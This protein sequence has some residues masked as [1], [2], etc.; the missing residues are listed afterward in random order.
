MHKQTMFRWLI[1]AA[2]AATLAWPGWA[3]E[4]VP[5]E[6]TFRNPP[7]ATRPWCY[8]YWINDQISKE[9]VT[10]DLEAMAQVGIGTALIGNQWFKDQ[11]QGPYPVLGD[12]WQEITLHAIREGTR[13][14][15]DI[16]LFNCPGWS[17]S[18][19]PW[20][21]QA[22]TMRHLVSSE[23]R[24]T[25][26][27][28]FS[29]TIPVPGEDF[30]D[31]ALLAIP[32]PGGEAEPLHSRRPQI[33]CSPDIAAADRLVDGDT[34]TGAM[35]N[36]RAQQIDI[37][38]AKPFTARS[39]TL[40]P[41]GDTYRARVLI[42]AWV[43]GEYR[44]L[45]E[46]KYDR[47]NGSIGAGPMPNGPVI[48]SIPP[49]TSDRFRLVFSVPGSGNKNEKLGDL[50]EIEISPAARVEYAV[51]KQLGKMHPTP[52]PLWGD[53]A[54]PEPP[55][56]GETDGAIAPSE[57]R[58][59]TGQI[60]G[61]GRLTCDIPAGE[62]ILQ[63]IGMVPTGAA[64]SPA[65]PNAR[66]PEIDKM[67]RTHLESHF[68]A[69]VGRVLDR[70]APEER[71]SLKYVVADSY[72]QGSQNWTDGLEAVFKETYGY[73]PIPYL[74]VLGGRIVKSAEASDRF[75]WDLRRMVADRVADEY[76]GG[77]RDL[78][79]QHHMQMWLENYGHW[80]FPSEFMRYGGECDLIAGEFWVT[81]ELGNIECRAAASTAHAYGKP[82]VYAEAFTSGENWTDTPR[83]LKARGDWAF[84]EGINHFVLHVYI[85]Q[86]D[87]RFVPG[88]NAWFGTE[89]NRHNTWFFEGKEWI[90]YLRRCHLL[91]QQGL[92]VGDFAYFIGEDAPIMTGTRQ[93]SQPDG[94]D[95]DFINAE[96]ILERLDV[97]DG[98]WTLPDG[99]SYAVLVLPPLKTMRPAVL[100]KLRDLVAA[101][102]ILYGEAP[103]R[104]PSLQ[105]A[106]QADAL[107]RRLAQEMWPGLKPG[108]PGSAKVGK[109]RVIQGEPLD[110]VV[111]SLGLPPD[112]SRIDPRAV[113][114]T[115]RTTPDREIYFLSNQLEK[116][117]DLAPVFRAGKG[118]VP[119]FWHPDTGRIA[120]SGLFQEL[121]GGTRVP[122]RLDP[123][124]SVFVV[125]R[126][127]EDNPGP[128]VTAVEGPGRLTIEKG[129]AG[130][131]AEGRDGGDYTLHRAGTNP[132]K[133]SLA[134]PPAPL[135]LKDDAW[136]LAFMPGRDAPKEGI[137]LE[138]L[139]FWTDLG[140][141]AVVHY[142][143]TAKYRTAFDVPH[144]LVAQG[145]LRHELNLGTVEPMARVRL[146]GTDLG[147]L[148]KP[149]FAVDVTGILRAG[150]NELEV[151]VTNLWSNR[152]LGELNYPDGFPGKG[153]KEFK[154]ESSMPKK[155]TLERKIQPSGLAGPVQVES[156][157][158]VPLDP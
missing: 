127:P 95:F 38:V 99:K 33:S 111:K 148:W 6:A 83:T 107:V 147:L 81:G 2:L 135:H 89:F 55:A 61:N 45:R 91:L 42:Q 35:L 157:R 122:L 58:N 37:R 23:V 90:D 149:P 143:G 26:P 70:L 78:C 34:A 50:S 56:A 131:V 64:N 60:D 156:S 47:R 132:S 30:Q 121:D 100:E 105:N 153:E 114:W 28:L 82:V 51:E 52:L 96:V 69:F 36:E 85:H 140:D 87:D 63:R 98:R 49:T 155:I 125:F 43:D 14:G 118:L 73:D 130:W 71:T 116:Q 41:A 68:N 54:W 17:Q 9:G 8:W 126:K 16:G 4:P 18:G 11:S 86:P 110:A 142:S 133:L 123:A 119:E 39:V 25:G 74:P 128:A 136:T 80:G 129:A 94:F 97:R 15:V 144:H 31:V 106:E 150:R 5:L 103:E 66:G 19:G 93:P 77:L 104:S 40:V 59:L 7:D 48:A 20:V 57:I 117:V 112:V 151:D 152:L 154:A 75:L 141:E 134:A 109:G 13:L 76:V 101:G 53:Y 108:V 72:E 3:N 32:A 120:R 92:H 12:E 1:P 65:A 158:R 24:A 88:M 113:L 115:H 22:E 46:C 102:G 139:A 146:N 137:E 27:G 67:N 29:G 62:W 44:T 145:D 79:N 21:K 10:K 124:G 84:T 138:W